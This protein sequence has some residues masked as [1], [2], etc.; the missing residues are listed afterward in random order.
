[1]KFL[2]LFVFLFSCSEKKSDYFPLK[3]IKSW[4]YSVEIIPEVE[5]KI[6]YK[7]TNTSLG[8]RK[9]KVEGKEKSVFP[10]L[11]EDGTTFYYELST[12][13]FLLGSIR[14]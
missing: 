1:M 8:E 13:I 6:L 7:K 5:K 4:T 10:V 14:N 2:L 11:R 3:K 12:S 9:I